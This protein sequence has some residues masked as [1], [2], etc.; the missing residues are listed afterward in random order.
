MLVLLLGCRNRGETETPFE[1]N[2]GVTWGYDHFSSINQGTQVQLSMDKASG[3]GFAS[4]V[5]YG[6]GFFRLRI[7]LPDRNSAGVVTAFYLTSS[8]S[9]HDELDM[10][11]LGNLENKPINLQTNVFVNGKGD[12]EQRFQLWFD[13]TTDFHDYTIRWNNHQIV[14]MVDSV[15][16]RVLKNVNGNGYPTFRAMKVVA[17]LWNGED[18]A[19]DGGKTKIDWNYSPFR[20]YFRGFDINGCP[21]SEGSDIGFCSST[22]YWWNEER[23]W[24]LDRNQQNSYKNARRKYMTY[25]Y[26]SDHGR[27][28]TPPS[29]CANQ[30]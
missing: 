28:P 29:E 9:G 7:K 26:C 25:D 27:F 14:F 4:K 30:G 24:S 12:R 10:E 6:S 3:S 16:I 21:A 17:S 20:A 1:M 18:W 23:Y 22:N 2:Y 15:P 8:G 19:T 13:P 11:F 5:S